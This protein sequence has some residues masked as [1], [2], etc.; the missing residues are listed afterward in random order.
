MWQQRA[1]VVLLYGRTVCAVYYRC[2][3]THSH[4]SSLLWLMIQ[5]IE[6]ITRVRACMCAFGFLSLL[7]CFVAPEWLSFTY[8]SQVKWS[9][10]YIH[11]FVACLLNANHALPGLNC[12][13]IFWPSHAIIFIYLFIIFFRLLHFKFS[14]FSVFW[15]SP[16]IF[17][18]FEFSKNQPSW[19]VRFYFLVYSNNNTYHGYLAIGSFLFCLLI[20]FHF[21]WSILLF[22]WAT[23]KCVS[24]LNFIYYGSF[25][26]AAEQSVS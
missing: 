8:S 11:V 1:T 15:S 3:G 25:M 18:A 4:R 17:V 23:H 6:I 5:K 12:E 13:W 2:H 21:L 24:G 7:F 20:I 26:A 14:K 9:S 16:L 10:Y 22:M 19:T